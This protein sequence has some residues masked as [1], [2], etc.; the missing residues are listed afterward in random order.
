MLAVGFVEVH[1]VR[2]HRSAAL[3]AVWH[4]AERLL[5]TFFIDDLFL[6]SSIICA[7]QFLKGW[8]GEDLSAAVLIFSRAMHVE[9]VAVHLINERCEGLASQL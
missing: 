3:L 5:D 4:V 9:S 7:V 2:L 8:C 1:H 6:W